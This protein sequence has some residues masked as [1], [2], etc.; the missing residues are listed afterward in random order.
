[1]NLSADHLISILRGKISQCSRSLKEIF[2]TI[3]KDDDGY[4]SKL[5][6]KLAFKKANIMI[7]E[8]IL[9]EAYSIFDLNNDDKVSFKEFLN[10]IFGF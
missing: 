8:R 1:M 10:V 3:D 9:E 4:I 7:E 5:E 2:K 6:F